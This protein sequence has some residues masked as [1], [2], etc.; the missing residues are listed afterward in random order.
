MD[1][2]NTA[3]QQAQNK[4]EMVAAK[5]PQTFAVGEILILKGHRFRI[6]S[7][8]EKRMVLKWL[9]QIKES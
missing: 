2:G 9:P 3:E 1:Q 4:S 8:K 7:M 5:K 6:Q